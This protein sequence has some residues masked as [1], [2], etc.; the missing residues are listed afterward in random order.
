MTE[1]A[2]MAWRTKKYI[3]LEAI[4]EAQRRQEM[5]GKVAEAIF[6]LLYL[7]RTGILTYN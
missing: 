1:I 4:S 5:C 7:S 2:M 6:C 3:I